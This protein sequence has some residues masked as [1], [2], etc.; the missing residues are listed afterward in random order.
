MN[1]DLWEGGGSCLGGWGSAGSK[2]G[3]WFLIGKSSTYLFGLT[4]F[5]MSNFQWFWEIGQISIFQ[6]SNCPKI[7]QSPIFYLVNNCGG[8]WKI[9]KSVNCPKFSQSPEN[10]LIS[11]PIDKVPFPKSKNYPTWKVLCPRIGWNWSNIVNYY[12]VPSPPW[13]ECQHQN[14]KNHSADPPIIEFR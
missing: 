10:L 8:N 6:F 3:Y 12:W 13:H 14:P 7:A 4:D 1:L 2:L 11:N 5:P 9:Q